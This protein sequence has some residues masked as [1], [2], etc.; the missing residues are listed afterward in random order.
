MELAIIEAARGTTKARPYDPQT[1]RMVLACLRD[2]EAEELRRAEETR[3]DYW[4]RNGGRHG[5]VWA[6]LPEEE[7]RQ[8]AEKASATFG[9]I[10]ERV[11]YYTAKALN[12]AEAETV[13]LEVMPASELENA[14]FNAVYT[15][16]DGKGVEDAGEPIKRELAH[17][18]VYVNIDGEEKPRRFYGYAEGEREIDVLRRFGGS[19][20]EKKSVC[21]SR[22]D[23]AFLNELI[24]ERFILP[25][26]GDPAKAAAYRTIARVEEWAGFSFT[27]HQRGTYCTYSR[28][29]TLRD[30][31]N[32]L[33]G[34]EIRT[35][36]GEV[37]PIR[38]VSCN[39]TG[40]A[41]RMLRR[42]V[43]HLHEGAEMPPEDIKAAEELIY[44][45]ILR[46]DVERCETYENSGVEEAVEGYEWEL[47]DVKE[48]TAEMYL[49]GISDQR[50][51][52]WDMFR[53]R[54]T[55]EGRPAE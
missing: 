16:L 7:D 37:T 10:M 18:D 24:I 5:S 41:M 51:R 8:R 47:L 52:A 6:K 17:F 21:T 28:K 11:T 13:I 9:E 35:E 43:K 39:F 15:A 3:R 30:I 31:D 48:D 2:G 25:T 55:V 53:D 14:A 42:Y 36:R 27:V 4:R 22:D 12:W 19:E 20:E 54:E 26:A 33:P 50:E 40:E 1:K 32:D 23:Y 45:R 44:D 38:R 49:F 46:P 34:E 29:R